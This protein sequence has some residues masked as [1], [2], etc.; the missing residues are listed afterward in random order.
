MIS[1]K[2]ALPAAGKEI[3][4]AIP[5]RR[6]ARLHEA[7]PVPACEA[8]F[9]LVEMA[10]VMTIMGLVLASGVSLLGGQVDAGRQKATK[11]RLQALEHSLTAFYVWNDRLPCP[12]DGRLDSSDASYGRSQP[13]T[14][15]SCDTSAV[16]A[17]ESVIPW[18]TL[19][20]QESESLDGW[21]RR[22]SY[23]VSPELTASGSTLD[24]S[25]VVRDGSAAVSGTAELTDRAAF[26]LFSHGENGHGAWLS[27][28][29]RMSTTPASTDEAL[30]NSGSSPFADRRLVG[31]LDEDYDDML[32][33]R[34]RPFLLQSTGATFNGTACTAATSL[35]SSEG[36][37]VDSSPDACIVAEALLSR[38]ST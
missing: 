19:G 7:P 22:I 3:V 21:G 16:T 38:C 15:G 6:A 4:R 26:V 5:G 34:E 11:T 35:W 25:L 12:A 2:T 36:C 14:S 1:R 9:S 32:I 8:G 13:E 30:N 17:A 23:Q 28:G 24:G 27:T 31:V 10:I 20:L 18:R 37:S 33:W 29:T